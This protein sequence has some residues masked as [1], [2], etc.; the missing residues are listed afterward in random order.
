MKLFERGQNA[1]ARGDLLKALEFYDEAI[2][3]RPEFAEAEFQRG[4]ALVALGRLQEAEAGFRRAI[5]L[6][7]TWSLPYSAL[8]ALLVRL[9]RDSDAEVVL[10]EAIKLDPNDNLGLRML[11]DVRLRSGDAKEAV[12][13]AR[14][15]TLDND[16]SAST[17]LLRAL[18]RNVLPATTWPRFVSFNRVLEIDPASFSALIERAEIRLAAGEKESAIADL[19]SAEP[20]AKGDKANLSRLAVD[21][22]SAGLAAEAKRIAEAAGLKPQAT[23][24]NTDK[25]KVDG[26]PEEIEAANSDDPDR[27]TKSFGNVAGKESSKRDAAGPARRRVSQ[28]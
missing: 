21:Y 18:T 19:R 15:A 6:R 8:G 11:A 4:S 17:W 2:K 25:L 28:S 3:V 10:R 7:K 26:T 14:R 20:L 1:H 9:N 27:C 24:S 16:A 12:E 5:E 23:A 22:E 13:L